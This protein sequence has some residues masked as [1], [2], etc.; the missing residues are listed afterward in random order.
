MCRPRGAELVL[1]SG[2]AG[3]HR[4]HGVGGGGVRVHMVRSRDAYMKRSSS[5]SS[6]CMASSLGG[7][8]SVLR[9]ST[10][11]ARFVV[12]AACRSKSC[13][14]TRWDTLYVLYCRGFFFF[15]PSPKKRQS[16]EHLCPLI[17]HPPHESAKAENTFA[18]SPIISP[19]SNMLDFFIQVEELM[20]L[21]HTALDEAWKADGGGGARGSY[22][23]ARMAHLFDVIGS[24]LCR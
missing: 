13:L 4:A 5:S 17:C 3:A 21:T 22:P 1:E 20:D 19:W 10:F 24:A 7:G 18:P 6:Q 23:Q 14:Q 12:L 9:L 8:R 16:R 15:I 11:P 2:C